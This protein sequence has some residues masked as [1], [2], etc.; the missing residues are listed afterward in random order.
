MCSCRAGRSHGFNR[1]TASEAHGHLSGTRI[2]HDHRGQEGRDSVRASLLKYL[3]LGNECPHASDSRSHHHCSPIWIHL[4]ETAVR[5]CFDGCG[6]GDLSKAVDPPD[7]FGPEDRGRIEVGN[8]VILRKRSLK[9]A[10]EQRFGAHTATR[11]CAEASDHDPIPVDWFSRNATD[12]H[13][14]FAEIRS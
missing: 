3:L 6:H 5:H 4:V 7:L 1:P 13:Q 10:G 8:P 9:E 14:S 2:G 12:E 11:E